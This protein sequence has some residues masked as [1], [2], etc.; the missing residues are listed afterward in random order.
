[1]LR[2]NHFFL[3]LTTILL[4]AG[5]ISLISMR[6]FIEVDEIF[7]SK[8]SEEPVATAGNIQDVKLESSIVKDTVPDRIYFP[9]F[10][11]SLDI[12]EGEIKDNKWTLYDDR[13]SWLSTSALPSE[14]NVILYA[15]NLPHLFG[16][17]NKL[18]KG[19]EIV[20]MYNQKTFKYIVEKV[21]KV[22]PN[23]IDAVTSSQNQLTLYTCDGSFDQRR[24]IVTALPI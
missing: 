21:V 22:L 20:V 16:N 5:M 23:D 4:V 12:S 2:N 15:H 13:V 1:M 10:D 7:A 11:L 18:S 24:L 19:D 3:Q 9:L 17:L 8:N 14:G 6:I